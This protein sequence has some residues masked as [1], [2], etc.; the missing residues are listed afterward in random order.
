MSKEELPEHWADALERR[1]VAS[2]RAI[3]RKAEI[4]PMAASRLVKGEP[5]SAKT[6]RQVA[7]ALFDGDRN[8]VWELHGSALRDHGDWQLPE[9]SSLLT[10]EQR[11]AVVGIVRAMLPPEVRGGGAG[12][13][14]AAATSEPGQRPDPALIVKRYL[15]QADGDVATAASLLA[16]DGAKGAN[17][18]EDTWFAA[19]E[20][21]HDQAPAGVVVEL[22]KGAAARRSKK[23]PPKGPG[24]QEAD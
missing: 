15:R 24:E 2:I 21:L 17:T 5:T 11:A 20:Q 6:V 9:E 14:R 16:H 10:D 19:L 3:A 18:D 12:A 8:K 13:K 7:D 23:R 4:S 22:P 1:G